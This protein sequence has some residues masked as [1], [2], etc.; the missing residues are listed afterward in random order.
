MFSGDANQG[1]I[2]NDTGIEILQKPT[3]NR[4]YEVIAVIFLILVY[5]RPF[6]SCSIQHKATAT[7]SIDKI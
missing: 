6:S 5:D 1:I 3:K 4:Y 2:L 7:L